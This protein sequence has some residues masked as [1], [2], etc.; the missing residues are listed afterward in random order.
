MQIKQIYEQYQIMPQLATH[1]LRVAG[2]GKLILDGWHGEIDC[3][4]VMKALLLH[5]MGNLAKFDFSNEGQKKQKSAELVDLPYWRTQQAFFWA[6]YGKQAHEATIAILKE[7]GQGEVISVLEQ[8]HVGY[9]N[10][11]PAQLIQQDAPARIVG[12][13][14]VRVTPVGVVSMKDR[15]ADLYRRYGRE[16]SWYD[17]LYTLEKDVAAMTTTDLVAITEASVEPYFEEFLSY[18]VEI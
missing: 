18:N 4:L 16:L 17:F 2:V 8:D 12:Y 10:G 7:L 5:D 13:A 11:Y 15:I 1:M 3:D 9:A 14:D 6:K